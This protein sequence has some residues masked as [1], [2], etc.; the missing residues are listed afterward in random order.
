MKKMKKSPI[1]NT[2]LF[3]YAF[4]FIALTSVAIWDA[5]NIIQDYIQDSRYSLVK[6]K[7][8]SERFPFLPEIKICLNCGFKLIFR[9]FIPIFS[10][11]TY[12]FVQNMTIKE[13]AARLD[14]I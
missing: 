11:N 13:P 8:I 7:N 4:A 1:G 14:Q 3:F 6:L 12:S 5:T 2:L 9:D 10:D